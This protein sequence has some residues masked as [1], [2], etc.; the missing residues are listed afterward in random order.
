[1][2]ALAAIHPKESECPWCCATT[3]SSWVSLPMCV[4]SIFLP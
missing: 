4:L 1:V 3:V 2:F